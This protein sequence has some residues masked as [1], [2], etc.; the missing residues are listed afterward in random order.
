MTPGALTVFLGSAP[1]VGKTY[2]MLEEARQERSNGTD[3]VVAWVQTYGR[4]LTELALQGLER[5]PP[6]IVSYRGITLEEMDLAAT[7]AR[8]PRVALVD[9][10][11]HTNVAGTAHEKRWQDVEELLAAGI[12]VWSSVN[13]QHIESVRDVVEQVTGVAVRETVPDFVLDSAR[14]LRLAD[15]TPEAL[16]KRMRH[17]NIYP[18]ERVEV[19]LQSFFREGNLTA[20]REL[21]LFYTV[22]HQRAQTAAPAAPSSHDRVLIL[23]PADHTAQGLIRRGVRMGRRLSAPVTVLA[24]EEAGQDDGSLSGAASLAEDLGADLRRCP[25]G[26]SVTAV[27]DQ[28]ARSGA[29]HLVVAAPSRS[30]SGSRQQALLVH[31]LGDLGDRHLHVIGRRLGSRPLEESERRPDPAAF[32]APESAR[33]VKGWL[34]LYLGYAPGVGKTTRMLEE[35]GR[36][37]RRGADVI[38]AAA[39]GRDRPSVQMLLSGLR[40]VPSLRTGAIDLDGVLRQ[41]P[42]VVCVD[43]LAVRDLNTREARYQQVQRL[44]EFGINVV[45][46]VG[47]IDLQ[48]FELAREVLEVYRDD[49]DGQTAVLP[50]SVLEG[51]E[52]I[53]LVDLPPSELRERVRSAWIVDTTRVAAALGVFQEGLLDELRSAALRRVA[54]HTEQRLQRYITT[55]AIHTVW[56]VRERIAVALRSRRV[57]LARQLLET[58]VAMA[59]REDATL[60]LATVISDRPGRAESRDIEELAKLAAGHA[61]PLVPIPEHGSVAE[62]LVAWAESH[63]VTTIIMPAPS[64]RRRMPWERPM[65]L[66]VIRQARDT[67]IHIVGATS[68]PAP[69]SGGGKEPG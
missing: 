44:L 16:R 13:I 11:A 40:L 58:G 34:R 42:S 3:V 5:I 22:Q 18:P 20:L 29:T 4:P 53:E 66:E 26:S 65:A 69:V 38:V 54:G 15:I 8:H 33:G 67:D 32:L 57:T 39:G 46:T 45:G 12:D 7:L 6:Q 19:A 17:G 25:P 48:G 31:L 49:S 47:V 56:A 30:R 60:V 10:L 64:L 27:M 61:V 24:L 41:N 63:Q 2:S 51:A 23:A 21:A 50:D 62:T 43:D 35:A 52:E 1:G 59:R 14:E 55:N 68:P 37:Q 36:R 9:E 28:I